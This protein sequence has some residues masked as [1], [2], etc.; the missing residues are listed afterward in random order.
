MDFTKNE[1]MKLKM[2]KPISSYNKVDPMES[3]KDIRTL[4]MTNDSKVIT[5]NGKTIFEAG[6]S[7]YL[8]H[9][10]V[11]DD[12]YNF[13]YDQSS[14][15]IFYDTIFLDELT[16]MIAPFGEPPEELRKPFDLG[17]VENKF[18]TKGFIDFS[19]E[20][21]LGLSFDIFTDIEFASDVLNFTLK[22]DT[23]TLEG[24]ILPLADFDLVV[25]E[26]KETKKE[27][28]RNK[29]I[30]K[31]LFGDQEGFDQC[32]IKIKFKITEDGGAFIN[33]RSVDEIGKRIADA[34]KKDKEAK[35]KE[36]PKS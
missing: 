2:A 12:L 21:S 3:L 25:F 31:D 18:Y 9:L 13:E 26:D 14:N 28:A 8:L 1:V 29:E 16:K 5:M 17:R 6:P 33:D 30:L 32:T 7:K 24:R 27:M 35:K 10:D 19:G 11:K 22:G 23:K 34:K 4:E 20:S 15:S 36:A